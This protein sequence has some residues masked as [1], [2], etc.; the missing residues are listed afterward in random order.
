MTC[1]Q[2]QLLLEAFADRQ[3]GWGTAWRVRRHLVGCG[4]CAAEMAEIQAMTSRVRVWRD[5]SAPAGLEDRIAAALP[6][7]VAPSPARFSVASRRAAVGL[8]GATAAVAAFFWL[9][10]GQPGRPTIAYA[11]VQRAMLNVKI[12]GWTEE[13]TFYYS[14]GRVRKHNVRKVWVSTN[15]PML[16]DI[17]FP[18]VSQPHQTQ[19][20]ENE[21]GVAERNLNGQYIIRDDQHK[22]ADEVRDALLQRARTMDFLATLGSKMRTTLNGQSVVKFANNFSYICP[23]PAAPPGLLPQHDVVAVRRDIFWIDSRTHRIVQSEIHATTQ[24]KPVYDIK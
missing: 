19:S 1:D 4:L 18:T 8:A 16:A 3:L 15:P 2:I 14:D 9:V 23:Y 21:H 12:M 6:S 11:D 5:V 17:R 13:E 24:G 7:S 20:L 22:V 10:P